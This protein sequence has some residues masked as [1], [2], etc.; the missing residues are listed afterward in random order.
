MTGWSVT[1][2]VFLLKGGMFWECVCVSHAAVATSAYQNLG[3]LD[4]KIAKMAFSRKTQTP[5][6]SFR[7]KSERVHTM[8]L[9]RLFS[10]VWSTKTLS[11]VCFVQT[12]NCYNCPMLTFTPFDLQVPSW[13]PTTSVT[14]L[15]M[16]HCGATVKAVETSGR[17]AWDCSACSPTTPVCVSDYISHNWLLFL[18]TISSIRIWIVGCT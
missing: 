7:R 16:C 5:G 4:P 18:F 14:V 12:T 17:T 11:C 6:F 15:Q 1:A 13:P 3:F 2:E 9:Y 8:F 10:S